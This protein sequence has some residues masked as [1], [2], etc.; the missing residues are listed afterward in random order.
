MNAEGKLLSMTPAMYQCWTCFRRCTIAI[1]IEKIL[2]P[3]D[4]SDY[5]AVATQLACELATKYDSE[6]HL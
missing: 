2:L 5:G 3:T 1:R 6:L 4:F